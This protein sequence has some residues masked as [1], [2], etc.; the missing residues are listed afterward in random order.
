M[1][2]IFN[3]YLTRKVSYYYRLKSTCIYYLNV[4]NININIL[5]ANKANIDDLKWSFI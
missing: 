2:V 4:Y 3:Q 5:V 1:L